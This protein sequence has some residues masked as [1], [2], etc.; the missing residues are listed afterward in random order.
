MPVLKARIGGAWVDVGGGNATYGGT[1][2]G[3]SE[4]D[5][6]APMAWPP[7]VLGTARTNGT[8]LKDLHPG[9]H[10]TTNQAINDI[11]AHVQ[12][13]DTANAAALNAKLGPLSTTGPYVG[14]WGDGVLKVRSGH[15]SGTTSA[16]GDIVVNFQTAFPAGVVAVTVTPGGDMSG[17]ALVF[18]WWP[19]VQAVSLAGLTV[20]ALVPQ[21][22]PGANGHPPNK[23]TTWTLQ[24]QPIAFDYYVLGT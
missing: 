17:N 16:F 9:D 24:Q 8:L 13:Q 23:G 5:A 6:P 3:T 18:G 14:G 12:A 2:P 1:A 7:P 4:L 19:F 21:G 15:A 20:Y 22:W 11:V 10:N